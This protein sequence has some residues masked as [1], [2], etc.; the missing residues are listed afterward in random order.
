MLRILVVDD[1]VDAADTLA[2]MLTLHGHE[3]HAC[4]SGSAALARLDSGPAPDLMFIDL[5]M[6]GMDGFALCAAVRARCPAPLPWLV[7]L[8]GWG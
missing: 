7:A 2:L 8:S 3:A 5:G 4:H 6:P 1:N